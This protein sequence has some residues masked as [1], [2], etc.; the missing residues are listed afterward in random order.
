[1]A[2]RDV[3]ELYV[4]MGHDLLT[5]CTLFVSVRYRTLRACDGNPVTN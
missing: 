4:V 2:R 1:M 5:S 3:N